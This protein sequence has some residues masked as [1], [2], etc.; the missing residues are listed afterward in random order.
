[1]NN[2][3]LIKDALQLAQDAAILLEAAQRVQD[4]HIKVELLGSAFG[5][6]KVAS[7]NA[8]RVRSLIKKAEGE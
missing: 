8:S 2:D 6:L 3:E 1:M 7:E 5:A 4:S